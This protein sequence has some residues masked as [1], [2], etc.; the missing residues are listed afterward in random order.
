MGLRFKSWVSAWGTEWPSPSKWAQTG[1]LDGCNKSVP[2]KQPPISNLITVIICGSS[3]LRN[4]WC[5]WATCVDHPLLEIVHSAL[6]GNTVSPVF[7]QNGL[8]SR[9]VISSLQNFL[10]QNS[11]LINFDCSLSATTLLHS[12]CQHNNN[13]KHL[14]S[15]FHLQS[16]SRALTN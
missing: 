9:D 12:H 11:L 7:S 16:T 2:H 5:K 3:Q 4:S 10:F 13:T 15:H 14:Y 6:R 8:F 1:F